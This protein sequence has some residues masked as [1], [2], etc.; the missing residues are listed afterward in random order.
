MVAKETLEDER[1]A[2]SISVGSPTGP[3]RHT[4][5]L[6]DPLTHLYRLH[7]DYNIQRAL[8]LSVLFTA[9]ALTH[10]FNDGE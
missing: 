7:H 4:T 1:L 9:K 8:Y 10:M 2:R 3:L 5:I 6:N